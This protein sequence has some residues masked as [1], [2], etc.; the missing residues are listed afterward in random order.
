M[1][2]S[3]YFLTFDVEDSPMLSMETAISEALQA[4][5]DLRQKLVNEAIVSYFGCLPNNGLYPDETKFEAAQRKL[6]SVLKS[7]LLSQ[8]WLSAITDKKKTGNEQPEALALDFMSIDPYLQIPLPS[9]FE[10]LRA[11]SVALAA[12]VGALVGMLIVTPLLRLA[13]GLQ[14]T[15]GMFLGAPLGAFGMVW[16]VRQVSRVP[17]LRKALQPLLVAAAVVNTGI[18]VIRGKGSRGLVKRIFSYVATVFLL[19]H[20]TPQPK[21]DRETHKRAVELAVE[22]WLNGAV[23]P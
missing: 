4:T 13:L 16:L 8:P 3:V 23:T 12:L 19:R 17:M 7:G 22:Q 21:Y 20:I 1:E 5:K 6:E 10:E 11:S 2:T 14:N 15:V 18:A 9:K